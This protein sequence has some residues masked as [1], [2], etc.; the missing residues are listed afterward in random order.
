MFWGLISVVNEFNPL[1]YLFEF[2]WVSSEDDLF[3]MQNSQCFF[4]FENESFNADEFNDFSF[5]FFTG[6]G[7]EIPIF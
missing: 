7:I 2:G 4:F 5:W 1:V 6:F 3:V